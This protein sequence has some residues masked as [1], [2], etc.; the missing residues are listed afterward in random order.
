MGKKHRI[1]VQFTVITFII[2]FMLSVQ[3]QSVN[4]KDSRDTRSTWDLR[5][6]LTS[7][8]E[9][10]S[11]LLNEIR[12]TEEKVDKYETKSQEAGE[13]ALRETLNELKEEAGL[14]DIS[15]PGIIL[16]IQPAEESILL[17]EELHSISPEMLK[18]LVN[19]LN[20]YGAMHI[21]I[22]DQR[23]VNH[24]VIRDINGKTKVN[25]VTIDSGEI[26][27]K[28]ATDSKMA[29][30]KMFNYMQVS[31]ITDEFFIEGYRVAASKPEQVT[32]LAYDQTIRINN[33]E[34][35]ED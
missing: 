15:G 6:E 16:H 34:V 14:T 9:I 11:N 2:G 17:G 25:G 26:E 7:E 32:I 10:Q 12:S 21:S 8:K 20:R 30:E 28:A 19:E 24:T 1:A 3:Y 27:I 13:E 29:A 23:I 33:L 35:A 18:R 22:N 31:P 5:A 4:S